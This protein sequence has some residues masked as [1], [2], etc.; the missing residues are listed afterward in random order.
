MLIRVVSLRRREVFLLWQ[1]F[2]ASLTKSTRHTAMHTFLSIENQRLI[3]DFFFRFVPQEDTMH[4]ELTVREILKSYAMMR[5]PRT[6]NETDVE[7][8]VQDVIE[9]LQVRELMAML[10]AE[11]ILKRICRFSNISVTLFLNLICICTPLHSSPHQTLFCH[12]R[13]WTT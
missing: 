1:V 8:V 12:M 6:F 5:L 13:S 9:A 11:T 2:S 7:R 3:D 4:R 10:C